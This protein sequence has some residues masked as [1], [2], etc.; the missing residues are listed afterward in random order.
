MKV[1]FLDID[2]VLNTNSDRNISND[3]LRLL[4]ELVLKTDAEV[5]L[6]STWRNVWNNP[7][8]NFPGSFICEWKMQFLENGIFINQIL[9]PEIPK[10]AAIKNYLK[11]FNPDNFV[12][13]DD[14]PVFKMNLIQTEAEKGITKNDCQKAELILGK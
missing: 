13:I 7:D 11:A 9:Q 8:L 14:H 1:I 10:D 4:S 3:K 2:G 12:V 6:S 5:V